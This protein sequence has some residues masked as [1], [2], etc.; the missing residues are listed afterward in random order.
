MGR[1]KKYNTKTEIISISVEAEVLELIDANAKKI[2]KG[3]SEFINAILNH[4]AYSQKEFCRMMARKA[5]QDLFYW[6]TRMESIDVTP[7][8]YITT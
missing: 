7:E 4:Y 5:Q 3:R 8:L 6:K 1:K 2:D